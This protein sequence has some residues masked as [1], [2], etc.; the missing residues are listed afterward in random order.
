[1]L[2][3]REE[4]R[5]NC[6]SLTAFVAGFLTDRKADSSAVVLDDDV[7]LEKGALGDRMR[8]FL[9]GGQQAILVPDELAGPLQDW[10]AR[11][12]SG[13]GLRII[14]RHPV[15]TGSFAFATEVYSRDVSSEIRA[16]V[17]VP[18]NDELLAVLRRL[19]SRLSSEWVFPNASGTRPLDGPAFDRLVFRSALQAARITGLRW[20]RLRHTFATR[21]REQGEDLKTIA[22]LMGHTSTRMTERY[23]HARTSHPHMAV[24]RISRVSLNENRD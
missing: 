4:I 7:G 10:I 21:L 2:S 24:Q 8:A 12:G 6:E 9:H 18:I 11:V 13:V 1:V 23:A 17:V 3:P 14:E 22:E 16:I 19:P 5:E 15:A 20:K